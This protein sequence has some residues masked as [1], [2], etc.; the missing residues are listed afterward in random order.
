MST[1]L[2]FAGAAALLA[3][4]LTACGIGPP[5]RAAAARP[6]ANPSQVYHQFSQCVREHGQPDFPDP[7]LD[8]QGQ[9]QMPD[10]VQKPPPAIMQA[11]S[12]IL[13]QLPASARGG[14][15]SG[16]P[17]PAMMRRFAQCMRDHGIDDWPDPDSNGRFTFPPSLAGNMKTG[18]RWPQIQAAWNGPCRQYDPSGHIEGNN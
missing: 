5:A 2:R 10:G 18:P 12:S 1:T 11:C 8:A 7:V 4:A 9:P 14:R 13:D 3:L 15:A 16:T 17:D 6:S